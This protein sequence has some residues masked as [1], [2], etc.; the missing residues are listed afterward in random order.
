[1][2]NSPANGKEGTSIL[3]TWVVGRNEE[4]EAD[5]SCQAEAHHEE[6]SLLGPISKVSSEDRSD[7]S[8]DVWW[9]A[10]QLGLFVGVTHSLDDS[11]EEEGDRVERSVDAWDALSGLHVQ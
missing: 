10:H 6:T 1:M 9:D 3:N 2:A 11:G 5:N 7:T 8:S 4:Y